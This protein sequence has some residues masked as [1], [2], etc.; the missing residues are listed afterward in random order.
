MI[1]VS[2]CCVT[3]NHEAFLAQAIESVIA[4][5]FEGTI[6]MIIG[7]DC[8]SDGTKAIAI[9]Y[10]D[11]FPDLIK[12]QTNGANVGVMANLMSVLAACDGDYI[13]ILDGDDYWTDNAKV[14]KQVDFLEKNNDY[15]ICAHNLSTVKIDGK[16]LY[17]L[18]RQE[19]EEHTYD[20]Q[21]LAKTNML[22]TASCMYRN[23][24]SAGDNPTGYPTWLPLVKIGDYCLNML[25]ARH[26]KAKYFPAVM[27]AYRIHN[28]GTWNGENQAKRL[29]MFFDTV[30][31]LRKEFTGEVKHLLMK[32]QVMC[33]QS[34]ASHGAD[35]LKEFLNNSKQQI[36]DLLLEDY[37][38]ALAE[39]L[40]KDSS[41]PHNGASFAG[42]VVNKILIMHKKL[43][44]SLSGNK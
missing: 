22:P 8:S 4:Q 28:S 27:G 37:P 23:N 31:Y 9:A 11:K 12:V 6:E 35:V 39:L 21:D 42:R 29:I 20:L 38:S 32:Q 2:V 44:H 17:E 5:K 34:V 36:L 3:Y 33:L 18:V 16:P 14:Q 1:K 41:L 10:Q 43:L 7:E 15:A 40:T 25:A 19:K 26:G 24:F 13:C 30:H